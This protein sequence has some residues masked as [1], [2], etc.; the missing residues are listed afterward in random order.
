MAGAVFRGGQRT[1]SQVAVMCCAAGDALPA[2]GY[3]QPQ[4]VPSRDGGGQAELAAPRLSALQT[5][6]GHSAQVMPLP[7]CSPGIS[8]APQRK[9]SWPQFCSWLLG[10]CSRVRISRHC[11]GDGEEASTVEALHCWRPASSSPAMPS[12]ILLDHRGCLVLSRWWAGNII[13]PDTCSRE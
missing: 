13:C 3:P 5:G 11:P 1:G 10:S 6:W 2:A 12:S 9:L 4:V 8:G 7:R